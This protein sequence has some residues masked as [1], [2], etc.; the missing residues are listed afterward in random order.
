MVQK[1]LA[2]EKRRAETATQA[3]RLL[4]RFSFVVLLPLL[5]FPLK[6]DRWGLPLWSSSIMASVGPINMSVLNCCLFFLLS[7]IRREGDHVRVAERVE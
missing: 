6:G 2:R 7:L 4:L 1:R 3:Q 5:F